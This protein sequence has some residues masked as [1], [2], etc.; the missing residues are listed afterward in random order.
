[1]AL[2][3]KKRQGLTTGEVSEVLDGTISQT[4]VQRYLDNGILTGWKNPI[5]GKRL[6]DLESVKALAKKFKIE[7]AS[8]RQVEKNLKAIRR[9][10]SRK[11]EG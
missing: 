11:K 4:T 1:M 6:I 10:R 3:L 2:K 9:K 5:T 8:E 7:L